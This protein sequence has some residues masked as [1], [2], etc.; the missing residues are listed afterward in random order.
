MAHKL[1]CGVAPRSEHNM[2]YENDRIAW[3]EEYTESICKEVIA[4]ANAD[5]GTI[6]VGINVSQGSSGAPA[7]PEQFS[8]MTR[9]ADGNVFERQRSLEQELSFEYAA[10]I[11]AQRKLEF[12]RDQYAALGIADSTSDLYTNLGLLLSDQCPYT[13]KAAVFSDIGNTVFRDR[14]EF[15]G[16]ILKQWEEVCDYLQLC[17]QNRAVTDGRERQDRWDYPEEA[18]REALLNALVHR[19]YSLGGSVIININDTSMEFISTGGL[20]GGLAPDDIRNGISMARNGGLAGIFHQLHF[21]ESYGVGIRR[22]YSLYQD[23]AVQPAISAAPNSFRITLPNSSAASQ[24][25]AAQ[26]TDVRGAAPSSQ[27]RRL[28]DYLDKYETITEQEIQELLGIRR[29]RTY[30]LTRQMIEMGL[31]S[32]TGR[33][34]DKKYAACARNP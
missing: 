6:Y 9:Y 23:C 31:I 32:A 27:M 24:T 8:L 7:S 30:L 17:N 21:M 25:A 14:R 12:G 34:T 2:R 19:D 13:V 28:L 10:G 18:I 16:S 1:F 26:A 22:I 33:G 15:T 11:F 20:I 29:T 4:F 3:E 5:G